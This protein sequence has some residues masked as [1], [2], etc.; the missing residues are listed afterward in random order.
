MFYPCFAS[1]E[2]KAQRGN[3]ISAGMELCAG[4]LQT[5]AIAWKLWPLWVLSLSLKRDKDAF[6][7]SSIQPPSSLRV[8]LAVAHSS[9]MS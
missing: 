8:L 4:S 5:D 1:G 9:Q 7:G 3:V 2:T 6:L